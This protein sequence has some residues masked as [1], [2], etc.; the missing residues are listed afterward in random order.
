MMIKESKPLH[1]LILVEYL[2]PRCGSNMRRQVISTGKL[3][4]PIKQHGIMLMAS[5]SD[6]MITMIQGYKFA[7]EMPIP[8]MSLRR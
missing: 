8:F 6:F 7:V 1:P 4:Y 5:I 2:L 3:F